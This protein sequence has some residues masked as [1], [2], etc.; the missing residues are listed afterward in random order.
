[1]LINQ[2]ILEDETADWGWG[3]GWNTNSHGGHSSGLSDAHIWFLTFQLEM[4]P[5]P[6]PWV[7]WPQ[8]SLLLSWFVFQ[9]TPW[10]QPISKMW[11][12]LVHT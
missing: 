9:N 8:G 3:G 1:M 5:L 12:E 11:W 6:C 2:P 10:L 7:L 4:P